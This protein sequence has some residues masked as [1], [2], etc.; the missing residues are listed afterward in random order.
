ME[1]NWWKFLVLGAVILGLVWMRQGT[2]EEEEL[3]DILTGA[4]LEQQVN[5]FLETQ[6]MTLPE[7]GDRANLASQN[8]SEATGVATREVGEVFTKFHLLASLPDLENGLY[9]AYV[10]ND[11]DENL[12]L[13]AMNVRKGGYLLEA[14]MA[15]DVSGYD[16]VR[17]YSPSSVAGSLGDLVLQGTFDTK[18][19]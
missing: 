18:T 11:M 10:V 9:E 13:G 6:N 12:R 5:D 8:G 4:A 17:I 14:T 7:G 3:G 2:S 19:L 15:E 16:I 1:G